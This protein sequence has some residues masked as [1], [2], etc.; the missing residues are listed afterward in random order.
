MPP[1]PAL[2]SRAVSPLHSLTWD[3]TKQ[4]KYPAASVCICSKE[5]PRGDE[6]LRAKFLLGFQYANC[7]TTA[8]EV[9]DIVTEQGKHGWTPNFINIEYRKKTQERLISKIRAGRNHNDSAGL[10]FITRTESE[11][12]SVAKLAVSPPLRKVFGSSKNYIDSPKANGYQAIHVS[13]LGTM[14]GVVEVQIQT[15]EMCDQAKTT[16][17][18]YNYNRL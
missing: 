4:R 5:P 11:C 17:R 3:R 7:E 14:G 15:R 12:W 6:I 1:I 16:R 9:I 18:E 2:Y 13:V 8:F 10:R